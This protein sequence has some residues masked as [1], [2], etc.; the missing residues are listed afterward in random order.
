MLDSCQE[1]LLKQIQETCSIVSFFFFLSFFFWKHFVK[2]NQNLVSR[3]NLELCHRNFTKYF[4]HHFSAKLFW[5]QHWR[6]N[7]LLISRKKFH[8]SSKCWKYDSTCQTF[9]SK[10]SVSRARSFGIGS[11][12]STLWINWNNLVFYSNFHQTK[13]LSKWPFLCFTKHNKKITEFLCHSDFT[14]NQRWWI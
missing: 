6:W 10:K 13:K 1:D 14:L 9:R 7:Y 4:P 11:V 12:L 5:N 2:L 3:I 8:F